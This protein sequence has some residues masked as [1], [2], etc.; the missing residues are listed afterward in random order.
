MNESNSLVI[1]LESVN[2][3]KAPSKVERVQAAGID[4][5]TGY[6]SDHIWVT[7]DGR[8]IPIP[9]MTDD[10]L[11]NVLNY[12]KRGLPAYRKQIAIGILL[13]GVASVKLF[14]TG[15]VAEQ[16]AEDQFDGLIA[17]VREL[18][19]IPDEEFLSTYVPIYGVLYQEAYKRK[20]VI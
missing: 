18:E 10:H 12:I 20:L 17:K 19:A 7:R 9:D 16:E 6:R 11:R 15:V 2:N 3:L 14:W 13:K 8:R 1:D 5:A 4:L